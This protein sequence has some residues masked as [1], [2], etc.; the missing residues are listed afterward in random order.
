[1]RSKRS[2][3][4]I[5]YATSEEACTRASDTISECQGMVVIA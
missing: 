5:Y 3:Y 4:W 2:I 1:M